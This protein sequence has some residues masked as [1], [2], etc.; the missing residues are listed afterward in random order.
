MVVVVVLMAGASAAM[1]I[2]L[3]NRIAKIV[4]DYCGEL[5]EDILRTNFILVYEL[6][7][8]IIDLGRRI[9]D[10]WF[11][12]DSN[13][14][15]PPMLFDAMLKA[16]DKA[17]AEMGIFRGVGDEIKS[18]ARIICPK[19][20]EEK[21]NDPDNQDWATEYVRNSVDILPPNS[22]TEYLGAMIGSPPRPR[23][24]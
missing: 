13:T 9:M 16:L 7:D 6:L 18:K 22:P 8:E 5:N 12:D 17:L 10:L 2:E 23:R 11:M 19:E 14:Y 21:W 1:V 3:L 24:A 20:E 15:T 4:K